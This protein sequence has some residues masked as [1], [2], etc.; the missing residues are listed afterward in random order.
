[1]EFE[2]GRR[3]TLAR[4]Q[5]SVQGLAGSLNSAKKV[6][7]ASTVLT[8]AFCGAIFG[9]TLVANEASKESHVTNGL[10]TTVDGQVVSTSI[11]KGMT[12]LSELSAEAIAKQDFVTFSQDGA[13][14]YMQILGVQS[15]ASKKVINT[16]VGAFEVTE[17]GM[18]FAGDN[19]VLE[20]SEADKA[21]RKAQCKFCTN[22]RT[23]NCAMCSNGRSFLIAGRNPMC[24]I[25]N[26]E[27]RNF[28]CTV[29]SNGRNAQCRVCV[30]EGGRAN[31]CLM[32]TN[33]R[34]A[35]CVFCSNGRNVQCSFCSN[36]RRSQDEEPFKC[37]VAQTLGDSDTGGETPPHCTPRPGEPI[38]DDPMCGGS[39]NFD[40]TSEGSGGGGTIGHVI[41]NTDADQQQGEE[42]D[43]HNDVDDLDFES[44]TLC[45]FAQSQMVGGCYGTKAGDGDLGSWISG[46]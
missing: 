39:S 6:L 11:N 27:G 29:C 5:L 15:T 35:Q 38:P 23:A 30:N 17:E 20:A 2:T 1:M 37:D 41:F 8:A 32:C 19:V 22:G 13:D 42:G 7:V 26:N 9:L 46:P 4:L 21:A 43:Q 28:Q 33:G 14:R 10:L 45:D 40:I 44:Y 12:S 24:A 25:C 34:N 3:S 18:T 16:I 36:G 31:Q